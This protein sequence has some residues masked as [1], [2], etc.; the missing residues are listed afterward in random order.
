MRYAYFAEMCRKCSSKR[1]MWQLHIRIKL[2]C[3]VVCDVV[4]QKAVSLIW[5]IVQSV[6]RRAGSS[7][8]VPLPRRGTADASRRQLA[9]MTVS[10]DRSQQP[11]HQD[12]SSGRELHTQ[13]AAAAANE[14]D[15]QNSDGSHQ[16][17][18]QLPSS[19]GITSQSATGESPT[20]ESQAAESAD[21]DVEGQQ[22]VAAAD[23]I[24]TSSGTDGENASA[25]ESTV[26]CNGA[27]ADNREHVPS[28]DS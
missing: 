4:F 14:D 23:T 28:T 10:E 22:G 7:T 21:T 19:T 6:E 13:P 16:S 9:F 12:S 3:L 20:A 17:A 18:T 26:A 2:T 24:V 15:Q 27:T 8:I 11:T 1:N 5:D 25:K